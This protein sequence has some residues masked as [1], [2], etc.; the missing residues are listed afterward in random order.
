MQPVKEVSVITPC[1]FSYTTN[2]I[3]E[4]IL[5]IFIENKALRSFKEY[6]YKSKLVPNIKTYSPSNKPTYSYNKTSLT[7]CKYYNSQPENEFEK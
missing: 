3:I 5:I 7:G 6:I 4:N 2:I 1:S